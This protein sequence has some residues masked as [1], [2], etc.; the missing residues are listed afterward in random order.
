MR[1]VVQ[2][3]TIY[4]CA[5]C[6]TRYTSKKKAEQCE[7]RT[8]EPKVFKVGSRVQ[9]VVARECEVEGKPYFFFGTV[10]KVI[11]PLPSDYEYE[12]KWL[13]GKRERLHAHVFLYHVRY[14]CPHCR[15]MKE[16]R[17]FTPELKAI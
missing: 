11:G 8:L 5:G 10:I 2:K 17:Y 15:E 12:V 16:E 3:K 7:R 1:I 4:I 14:R 6:K 13:G 9:N